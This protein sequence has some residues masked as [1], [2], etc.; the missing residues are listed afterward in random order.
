[1]VRHGGAGKQQGHGAID[2]S[3]DDL[4]IAIDRSSIENAWRV[5]PPRL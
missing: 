2:V 4:R 5:I 1:M 3:T